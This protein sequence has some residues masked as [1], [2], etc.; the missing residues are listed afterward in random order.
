MMYVDRV[1]R[2]ARMALTV[3]LSRTKMATIPGTAS[4]LLRDEGS[5]WTPPGLPVHRRE[6]LG[7]LLQLH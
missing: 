2:V 4:S 5:P 7:R 3:K 6:V 1:S